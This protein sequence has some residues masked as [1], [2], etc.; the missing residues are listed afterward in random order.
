[1]IIALM[2]T[3]IK[4]LRPAGDKIQLPMYLAKPKRILS[5]IRDSQGESEEDTESGTEITGKL[6]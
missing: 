6:C 4:D 2:N 1:M 5:H 3:Q